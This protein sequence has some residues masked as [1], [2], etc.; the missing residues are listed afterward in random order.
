M[1]IQTNIRKL[2]GSIEKMKALAAGLLAAAM[3]AA[4]L[5]APT[6]AQA[7][8]FP[9]AN[10][11]IVFTSNRTTGTGVN[12]PEGEL[13]IFT[14]NP[15]GTGLKQLTKNT[16]GGLRCYLLLGWQEDCLRQRYGPATSTSS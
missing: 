4:S 13:E 3:M 11:K 8:A 15:D 1:T 12:N 16:A 7:S 10:G 5:L 9:G 14:M 2:I 6:P